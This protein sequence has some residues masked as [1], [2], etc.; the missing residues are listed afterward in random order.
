MSS[1]RDFIKK[2][3]IAATTAG[4]LTAFDAKGLSIGSKT[5]AKKYPIVISTWDFGI[6]ANKAAWEILSKGGKALDAV[7]QGVRVPEAD[8][9]NMTVGKGGY[10]DRDGHVTLDACIM[11]ADGNCGA[12]AGMEKIGHP[13]SVARLVMEKTPHVMLVGEGALQ[14]ALENGFKE[15]NLLTPEG[16]KA[17]KEWLK[18]KKYKP[19]ANI[20]NQSFAAERL[21]G[22]QYNHDTIGMLALD[23]N[24][25]ISGACTTSGMAFKMHGRV[26]DSPI[27]GAGLY[28]DNEVGGATS[29]GVGEEVIRNVGSFLVVELMRQGYSPEDACKEAVMRIVKKKPAIAK[30]IQVGFLAMNKKGEYG[31]YALQQGFSYAVCDSK[32]QDLLIKGKHYYSY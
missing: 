3:L 27:I 14:F 28:V 21:P 19:V 17:W 32:Q 6:A 1:R 30:E 31:A 5:N 22:N 7:E 11:D 2:G 8:L 9:K 23:A 16:E 10:P 4:T 29:T 20:E 18:E 25:N 24:G 13:I 26:G 12:V 15:E